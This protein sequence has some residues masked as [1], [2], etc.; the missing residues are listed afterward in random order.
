MRNSIRS[1]GWHTG[2]MENFTEEKCSQSSTVEDLKFISTVKAPHTL[3]I[4]ASTWNEIWWSEQVIIVQTFNDTSACKFPIA[5]RFHYPFRYISSTTSSLSKHS[6][7]C[8]P[9]SAR[10]ACRRSFSII[11]W[12]RHRCRFHKKSGDEIQKG[13]IE[14]RL[15][16]P[17]CASFCLVIFAEQ[18]GLETQLRNIR[19]AA[20]YSGCVITSH[21]IIVC[22]GL[23]YCEWKQ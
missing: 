18:T 23:L 22:H 10:D 4:M 8:T 3:E 20:T 15:L 14:W 11:Y 16:I 12:L 9:F 13:I 19:I 6:C 21:V 5:W 17:V 7:D 2:M 1:W